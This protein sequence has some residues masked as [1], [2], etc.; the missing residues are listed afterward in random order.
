[1]LKSVTNKKP[2]VATE[3]ITANYFNDYDKITIIK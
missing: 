2:R 1:M 3:D